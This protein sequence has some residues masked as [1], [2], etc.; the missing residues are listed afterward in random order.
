MAQKEEEG[1]VEL[2]KDQTQKLVDKIEEAKGDLEQNFAEDLEG[3]TS[4]ATQIQSKLN[5]GKISPSTFVEEMAD[6]DSGKV[7]QK[8]TASSSKIF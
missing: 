7:I 6:V 1:A 4:R 8:N 2:L 3:L 5:D